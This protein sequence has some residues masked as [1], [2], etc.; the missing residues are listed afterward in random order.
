MMGPLDRCLIVETNFLIRQDLADLLKSLGIHNV[1]EAES[2]AQARELI[3]ANRYRLAFINIGY[4][5]RACGPVASELRR[6]KVPFVV[7]TADVATTEFPAAMR[8]APVM[9]KPYSLDDIKAIL[10]RLGS[11]AG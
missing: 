2:A 10:P 7:T 11:L 1:D 6:Q 3:A 5:D 4:A 9:S 8:N